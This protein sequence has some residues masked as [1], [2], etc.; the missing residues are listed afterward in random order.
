MSIFPNVACVGMHFRGQSAK[1]IVS[2]LEPG[3][4]FTLVREPENPYDAYALM[5]M[6]EDQHIGYIE[7]GQAAWISPLL[8]EGMTAVATMTHTEMRGKNLHPILEIEVA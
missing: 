7:R 3:A 1:D 4:S 8:D 2:L 5:V 6:F